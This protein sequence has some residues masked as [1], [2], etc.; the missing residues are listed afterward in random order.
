M[1][2]GTYCNIDSHLSSELYGQQLSQ[3]QREIHRLQAENAALLAQLGG[4]AFK[5][6]TPEGD[7]LVALAEAIHIG[8][9]FGE[10][11]ADSVATDDVNA[12]GKPK[13]A[14]PKGGDRL[15]RSAL[16]ELVRSVE[17]RIERFHNRRENDFRRTDIDFEPGPKNR[18]WKRDCGMYGR[19]VPSYHDCHTTDVANTA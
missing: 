18:C 8:L 15:A 2:R 1:A 13:S 19:V 12:K 4:G 6:D 9:A 5:R 7:V 17:S 3:R 11:A 14:E 10:P 16:R